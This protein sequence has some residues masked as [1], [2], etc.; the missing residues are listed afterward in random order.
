MIG[1]NISYII[2]FCVWLRGET[3]GMPGAMK[4][5]KV[6]PKTSSIS[7]LRKRFE[8]R[9]TS[10]QMHEEHHNR[11]TKERDKIYWQA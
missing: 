10:D 11:N 7:G 6:L 2:Y 1:N 8:V 4:K 9:L 3:L 5:N